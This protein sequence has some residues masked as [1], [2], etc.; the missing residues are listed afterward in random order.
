MLCLSGTDPGRSTECGRQ[1]DRLAAIA[2][3]AGKLL[4]RLELNDIQDD[5]PAV[6]L[7][8]SGSESA[9]KG[10]P[11]S[12]KNILSNISGAVDVLDFTL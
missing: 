1:T 9:P 2:K 5:E 6:I 10:V 7:F 12:Q 3:P 11:L 4:Q 8:T